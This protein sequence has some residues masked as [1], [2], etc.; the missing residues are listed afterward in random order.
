MSNPGFRMLNGDET[1]GG[2]YLA[3]AVPQSAHWAIRAARDLGLYVCSGGE[4]TPSSVAGKV[5]CAAGVDMVGAPV[6]GPY[7]DGLTEIVY[8]AED[9]VD[10]LSVAGISGASAPVWGLLE[11]DAQGNL[12]TK[13]GTPHAFSL[14]ED[15]PQLPA[16]T[17]GFVPHYGLFVPPGAATIDDDSLLSTANGHAKLIDLR[18]LVKEHPRRV[19]FNSQLPNPGY[20]APGG[21]SVVSLLNGATA[22]G[23]TSPF[24]SLPLFPAASLS[25]G[26]EIDWIISGFFRM[27]VSGN[28]RLVQTIGGTAVAFD[29]ITGTLGPD[30]PTSDAR[31]FTLR[32][33]LTVTAAGATATGQAETIYTIGQTGP[34]P[35]ALE[36]ISANSAGLLSATFDN[37]ALHDS[38]FDVAAQFFNSDAGNQA[39]IR[40]CAV[41]KTPAS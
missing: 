38:T 24:A 34:G 28:F 36:G 20:R 12:H 8:A 18:C 30:S 31:R 40:K 32:G 1:A 41:F 5:Q 4:V 29:S 9:P 39:G 25:P 26:D 22:G 6:D 10:A 17:P 33:S 3:M 37:D 16:P 11:K 15:G 27:G 14:G 2:V 21:S 23:G 7:L 13:A 35:A 19:L